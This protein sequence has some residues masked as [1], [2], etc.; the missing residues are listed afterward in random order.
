MCRGNRIWIDHWGRTR[1]KGTPDEQREFEEG[2][3]PGKKQFEDQISAGKLISNLK[4]FDDI[5]KKEK[6]KASR[7]DKNLVFHQQTDD[8]V[9]FYTPFSDKE[10]VCATKWCKEYCYLKLKPFK[11]AENKIIQS[12]DIKNFDI[13][14]MPSI[15]GQ[16]DAKYFTVFSS[17]SVENLGKD[18]SNRYVGNS[19]GK[20]LKKIVNKNKNKKIRF[21]IKDVYS[22][23]FL[24][25]NFKYDIPELAENGIIILSLDA[26][27]PEGVLAE[28]LKNK[29][30][31]GIS[32]VKHKDNEEL[33]NLLKNKTFLALHNLK[34]IDCKDCG[35]KMLCFNQTDR[36]ILI[37]DFR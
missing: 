16:F 22:G 30:I 35:D 17:G 36:F 3:I 12:T 25:T 23:T 31:R 5:K 20:Y 28:A 27:S 11:E 13:N 33:I 10:C 4:E 6:E 8:H 37:Q 7:A 21:F 24:N 14:V 26:T 9:S 15:I 32:V 1:Y 29:N 34:V 2:K 18:V 19:W